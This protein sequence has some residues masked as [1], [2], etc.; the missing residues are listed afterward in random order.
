MGKLTNLESALV[1]P[2]AEAWIGDVENL[3][4]VY[5]VPA[6]GEGSW[7]VLRGHRC[8][9]AVFEVCVFYLFA[10]EVAGTVTYGES[11]LA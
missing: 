5:G 7:V 10:G 4:A 11:S 2:E 3:F 6:V 1:G 9:V 8:E